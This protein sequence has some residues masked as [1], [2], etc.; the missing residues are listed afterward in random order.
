MAPA[1]PYDYDLADLDW[2]QHFTLSPADPASIRARLDG[3]EVLVTTD[4]PAYLGRELVVDE[5]TGV[6]LYRL[7]QLFGT[8]NVPGLEAGAAQP[9]RNRT[10]W[11][12]LFDVAYE[13][14]DDEPYAFTLSVYD[15]GTD[16]SCGLSAFVEPDGEPERRVYEPVGDPLEG[17]EFPGDDFLVGVV[18]LV[19]NTVEEPVPATYRELWI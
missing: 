2:F 13:P 7:V 19:L 6:A 1:G 14:P 10:T 15:Y 12:Y 11:Q 9:A 18:Q 8:P 5:E 16:V 4:L 3:A 17:I